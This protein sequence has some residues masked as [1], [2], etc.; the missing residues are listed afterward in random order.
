MSVTRLNT[1]LKEVGDLGVVVVVEVV[2][3]PQYS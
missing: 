1:F 3:M 2:N